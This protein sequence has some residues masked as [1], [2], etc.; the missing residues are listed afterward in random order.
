V[1]LRL[2]PVARKSVPDALYEQLFAA[3]VG[4]SYRPGDPLPTERELSEGSGAN[5]LAVREA[6]QRLRQVGLIEI[7]HGGGSSVTD[8]RTTADLSVLPEIV[9]I[10][11]A[12]LREELTDAL[13]RFRLA[14][15]VDACERLA[16][17]WAAG[18]PDA[19]TTHHLR[20]IAEHAD[21]TGAVEATEEFWLIVFDALGSIA[22]QLINNTIRESRLAVAAIGPPTGDRGDGAHRA[23]ADAMLAGDAK[24]ARSAVER[25]LHATI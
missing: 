13:C 7:V 5:R 4:G 6:M 16:H 10:D 3:I 15:G 20:Q 19:E 9:R 22:F 8:W 23:L 14:A 18:A 12:A 25:L 17:R 21:T 11:H 1:T 24:A 2:S